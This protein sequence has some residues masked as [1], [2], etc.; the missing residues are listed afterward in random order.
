MVETKATHLTR[1]AWPLQVRGRGVSGPEG[2]EEFGCSKMTDC[3][4]KM[5]DCI[6]KISNGSKHGKSLLLDIHSTVCTFPLLVCIGCTAVKP[7]VTNSFVGG[8]QST[9]F[10][11]V[12]K[13]SFQWLFPEMDFRNS[14][15]EIISL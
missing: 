8:S 7:V 13:V 2:M 15:Q 14:W 4:S 9:Y 6:W 3:I 11:V 1:Q 10:L 5:T 12:D